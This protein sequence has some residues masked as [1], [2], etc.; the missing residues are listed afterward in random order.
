MV[1][2]FIKISFGL[3]EQKDLNVLLTF[4]GTVQ[5]VLVTVC[6]SFTCVGG[7]GR[8][9]LTESV[10]SVRIVSI[11][12]GLLSLPP[13]ARSTTPFPSST[14]ATDLIWLRK[15]TNCSGENSISSSGGVSSVLVGIIPFLSVLR[16]TK[17][18]FCLPANLGMKRALFETGDFARL[19]P[20]VSMTGSKDFRFCI[21][22]KMHTIPN[23]KKTN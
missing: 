14:V 12:G 3:V 11:Q 1:I 10:S 7:G 17:V 18:C 9:C 20:F 15:E 22:S 19:L 8:G 5:V 16:D 2:V 21:V 4:W 23:K 6:R 13:Q